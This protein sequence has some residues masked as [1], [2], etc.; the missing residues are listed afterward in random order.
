MMNVRYF[1]LT[2]LWC[3]FPGAAF[4]Q[5]MDIIHP[6]SVDINKVK[7]TAKENADILDNYN[8]LQDA[9]NKEQIKKVSN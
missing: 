7:F 2:L 4:C 1:S 8:L 3:V 9:F 6:G 5:L